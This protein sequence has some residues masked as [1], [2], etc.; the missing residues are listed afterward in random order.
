MGEAINKNAE[1]LQVNVQQ[2][3][4]PNTYAKF[5][6]DMNDILDILIQSDVY[7]NQICVVIFKDGMRMVV[8]YDEKII[9][10]FK[11]FK[12]NLDKEN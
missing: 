2:N 5:L 3:Y 12:N 10:K 7:K 1:Y 8:S 6:L 4:P 11:N 9:E